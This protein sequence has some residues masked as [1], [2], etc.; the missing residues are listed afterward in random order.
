M[1]VFEMHLSPFY[2]T[3]CVIIFLHILG[4]ELQSTA[5]VLCFFRVY[6][7]S[8]TC[9]H[10]IYNLP[11]ICFVFHLEYVLSLSSQR[12]LCPYFMNI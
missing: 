12:M 3:L 4:T 1:L 6:Y 10:R 9:W 7:V 2:T 5:A 8:S 11:R